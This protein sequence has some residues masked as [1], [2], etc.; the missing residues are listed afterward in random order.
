MTDE[1]SEHVAQIGGGD[2]PAGRFRAAALDPAS[3]LT[4]IGNLPADRGRHIVHGIKLLTVQNGVNSVLGSVFLSLL[5]RILSPSDYG[6][7]SAALLVTG[8]GSSIAFFGLQSAA[9]R[10]V[11][12]S[13][14]DSRDLGTAARSIVILSLIFTSAAT[15]IFVMLSSRVSLYFTG[16]T[17]SAWVFAASGAWLFSSTISG[18]F[19]GLVQGMKKYETLAKILMTSNLAMVCFTALGLVE[20]HSILVPI[21][22]WVMYGSLISAW[23]L[24][25][26]RKN[27]LLVDAPEKRGET[28]NRVLRYSLPLGI[29]G[30]FTVATGAGDPLVVGKFLSSAQ[31]G[32]YFAAIAISG[33]L[34]V[35]LFTPL[36][37]AFFPETSS[38]AN[39]RK[40]LS[41]GLKLAIRYTALAMLPVSFSLAGLSRQ[42]IGLFSGGPSTYLAANFSLQLMSVFFL[43]VAMQGILT[44]LLLSTGKTV[45]VM[46]IG[47]VTVVLDLVLSLWLVPS[48]GILGATA[49]RI[50]VDIAGFLV[51]LYL[52]RD[53][54]RGVVDVVFQAKV[55]F[56]SLTM[57]VVLSGLSTYMSARTITLIPYSIIGGAVLLACARGMHLL[58]KED[59]RYLE[60]IFPPSIGKVVRAIL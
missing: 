2:L 41:N 44:T 57:L 46:M 48:F 26:T 12:Y 45:G 15:V 54:L 24:L 11:A 9:T 47:V 25:I 18:I 7:Y 40:G 32:E 42:M 13:S 4:G 34:G 37:T 29:A 14:H 35:I 16:S 31:M 43:F 3:L 8:I 39:D 58:S 36:N 55:L 51:A 19:Q 21:L 10:F 49:S 22:A 52:A 59:K 6:L 53:Y 60:S 30:V 56:A 23:S 17:G 33:G 27:H 50:L 1:I 38:N 5:L 20:F 28:V